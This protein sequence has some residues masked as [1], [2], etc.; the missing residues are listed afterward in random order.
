MARCLQRQ[1]EGVAGAGALAQRVD[2]MDEAAWS[3]PATVA[4][5]LEL[6]LVRE[7]MARDKQD[8]SVAQA[9][10]LIHGGDVEEL[11]AA[12]QEYLA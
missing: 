5:V 4:E 8:E 11:I 10:V 9:M 3:A 7:R 1:Q 6:A 2:A 12:L